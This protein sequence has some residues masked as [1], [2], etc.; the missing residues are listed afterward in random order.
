LLPK[1]G[2]ARSRTFLV[3]DLGL[4]IVDGVAALDLEGDGLPC[5]RLH[6]DLHL[7]GSGRS[8]GC[9]DCCDGGF[10]SPKNRTA[11]AA[12][13]VFLYVVAE[14]LLGFGGVIWAVEIGQCVL[15]CA[16][17]PLDMVDSH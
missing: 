1:D 12:R 6:E 14:A 4:D 16:L 5:Q 17:R 13:A 9:C 8:P 7:V 10:S 15:L 11:A 2:L 3:L